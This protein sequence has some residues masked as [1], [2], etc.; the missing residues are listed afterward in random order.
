M[1]QA[2]PTGRPWVKIFVLVLRVIFFTAIAGIPVATD[3]AITD[4]MLA[5]CM[6]GS[7]CINQVMP[8]VVNIGVVNWAAYALLWPLAAWFLGGKWLVT[9][10]WAIRRNRLPPASTETHL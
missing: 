3:R 2:E 5:G 1:T 9:R 4:F 10:L 7:G 6:P 8:L